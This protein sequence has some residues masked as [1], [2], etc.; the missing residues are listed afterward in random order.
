MQVLLRLLTIFHY[1]NFLLQHWNA[2]V[3]IGTHSDIFWR[4]SLSINIQFKG[5]GHCLYPDS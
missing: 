4:D 2:G 1:T 3:P 5:Q